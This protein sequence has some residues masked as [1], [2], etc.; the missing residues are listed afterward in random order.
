MKLRLILIPFLLA[1]LAITGATGAPAQ[2][3]PPVA[4]I[5]ANANYPDAESPLKDTISQARSMAD[6][7]KRDGFEVDLVENVSKEQ[8]RA[9][10]DR[11]YGKT[12][13]NSAALFFFSGFGVQSDRQTYVVPVNA[14]I[15]NEADARRDGFSLDKILAEMNSHGAKVKIAIVDAS[16]R[17]P[18][19]RRFRPVPAGLAPPAVSRGAAVMFAAAPGSVIRESERALFVPALIKE[20]GRPGRIEEAFTRTQLAVSRE[21]PEQAPW[22]S[23]SLVEE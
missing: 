2:N 3:E 14:Q 16:R 23:S 13:S 17:N 12:K 9:A 5:V 10:L 15:W 8:M 11:F 20:I 4:L 21:S 22:I 1:L 19:E 18:F 7:L 6:E